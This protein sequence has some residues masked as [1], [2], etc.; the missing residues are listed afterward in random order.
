M[1]SLSSKKYA[2]KGSLKHKNTQF[3]YQCYERQGGGK[4]TK[5]LSNELLG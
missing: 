5:I 2:M 3:H 1:L 4:G